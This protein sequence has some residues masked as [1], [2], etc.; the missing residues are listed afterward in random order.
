VTYIA[1]R[2]VTMGRVSIKGNHPAGEAGKTAP[3]AGLA[4]R[5]TGAF[6]FPGGMPGG[7]GHMTWRQFLDRMKSGWGFARPGNVIYIGEAL[8]K[9][10]LDPAQKVDVEFENISGGKGPAHIYIYRWRVTGVTLP[11]DYRSRLPR[12]AEDF[13]YIYPLIKEQ[14][15]VVGYR[16]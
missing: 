15:F 13:F 6:A 16:W 9:M 11:A 8:E 14:G 4:T 7:E 10:G 3:A 5:P 1:H 2:E 12:G